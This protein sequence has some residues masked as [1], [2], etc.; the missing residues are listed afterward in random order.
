MSKVR[1]LPSPGVAFVGAQSSMWI[2]HELTCRPFCAS[3]DEW[4]VLH[5]DGLLVKC[6]IKGASIKKTIHSVELL[7]VESI[8]HQFYSCIFHWRVWAVNNWKTAIVVVGCPSEWCWVFS[9]DSEYNISKVKG[10][11]S[12][13]DAFVGVQSLWSII[14][15]KALL[16]S[17]HC[18]EYYMRSRE[19]HQW[20]LY[21]SCRASVGFQSLVSIRHDLSWGPFKSLFSEYMF[22]DVDGWAALCAGINKTWTKRHLN[23]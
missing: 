23:N 22:L 2:S 18:S 1:G 8:M 10:L 6:W 17:A 4:M 16:F 21:P 14:E 7:L 20:K 5:I 9:L 19:K 15:E 12:P 13:G 11:L 3:V